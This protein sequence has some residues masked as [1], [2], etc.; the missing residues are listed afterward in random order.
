MINCFT[1]LY[2]H[3]FRCR[4]EKACPDGFSYIKWTGEKVRQCLFATTTIYQDGY[5]HCPVID[6]MTCEGCMEKFE[7]DGPDPYDKS[8]NYDVPGPPE[9]K[10]E[11]MGTYYTKCGREFKKSTKADVTG[12]EIIEKD[13][14]ITDSECAGCTFVIDV[15]EGWPSRVHKRFECRAGSKPPNHTNEYQGSA[16]DKNTLHV[17]SLDPVF[18]EAVIAF[19]KAHPDL[20]AS[21]GQD[22]L[23]NCRRSISI[24]PS[25]NKKGMAAKQELLD[26]FF[27][28]GVI[29]SD[30]D[31]GPDN[32]AEEIFAPAM[33]PVVPAAPEMT[34]VVQASRFDY[35]VLDHATADALRYAERAIAK[36]KMQT[37]YDIG[38]HLKLA[39]DALAKAGHGSYGAWCESIGFSRQSAQNY[40]QAYDFICQNFD[41]PE[42]ALGIQ[43]S[44]LFAA[45]KP[46][47][48]PEL[49]K[50][51]VDGDITQH[52]QYKEL[53]KKLKETEKKLGAAVFIAEESKEEL[54]SIKMN[55]AKSVMSTNAKEQR[56]KEQIDKANSETAKALRA[57][58]EAERQLAHAKKNASPAELERLGA[59]I[60]EKQEILQGKEREI[61]DLR[62]R[63][64][65][66]V[67]VAVETVEVIPDD[68]VE[69]WGKSIRTALVLLSGLSESDIALLVKAEGLNNYHY[70]K[71][72][73][74][75]MAFHAAEN[76]QAL[77]DAIISAPAPNAEF[78]KQMKGA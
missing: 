13:S 24:Y 61:A 56:L 33:E 51:V 57:K 16:K 11:I 28:A 44:L 60:R 42:K 40:M 75:M 47:A 4:N 39:N 77:Y 7:R 43:P 58:Q 52:K 62:E 37:V 66:P 10:E 31:A 54:Q 64:S 73:Y 78:I 26:K 18:C 65:A 32:F 6:Y 1:C 45:A 53:E 14:K 63:L 27:A 68:M 70:M 21:F 34:G 15:T 23:A 72:S 67:D 9:E 19:A 76:M 71:D 46:S 59:L 69:A 17:L 38:Q 49:A 12:Y 22:H 29:A 74:R 35:N 36:I 48:P 55:V 5:I 3:S 20:S 8:Q 25:A 50:A 41:R 30:P 2:Y